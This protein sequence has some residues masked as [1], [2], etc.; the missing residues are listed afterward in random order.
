[1]S[2]KENILLTDERI[3]PTD[4]Y[5]FSIIRDKKILW[6]SIMNYMTDNYKDSSGEWNFYNDGKKWLFKMVNRK[7]T[8]FWIG[9]LNDTFRVT[10]WFS[11]KA[12]SLINECSLS[13]NIKD[14]FRT[15]KKY[16]AIR[17][18]TIKINDN[19]DV[20]NVLRLIALKNKLK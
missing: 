9:I 5:I 4:E 16:G 11:D 13:E 3:Y 7:K 19:M 15:S 14:E 18:V 2:E 10:F 20:D 8:V 6:Q 1:M 17:A 12:E